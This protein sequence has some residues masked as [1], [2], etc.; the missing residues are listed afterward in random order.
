MVLP[1]AD[2]SRAGL[3]IFELH[4]STKF[5][6]CI[7]SMI[8]VHFETFSP[9]GRFTSLLGVLW[10]SSHRRYSV[11]KLFLEIWQNSQENTCAR[12]SF[13]IKLH[14]VACNFTKKRCSGTACFSVSFAKFLRTS[15]LTEHLRWPL[16]SMKK[17]LWK[18]FVKSKRKHLCRTLYS[19]IPKTRTEFIQNN[20]ATTA[21]TPLTD[22]L[23]KL[24]KF[25]Y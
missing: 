2:M 24:I 25:T 11:K 15:F 1:H 20:P 17:L 7:V 23:I 6:L 9:I 19:K 13:L 3:T 5:M 16:L 4:E 8:E 10:R 14:A 21:P 18:M 12:V 22:C